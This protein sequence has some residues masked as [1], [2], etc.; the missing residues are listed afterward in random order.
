MTVH[1]ILSNSAIC[2]NESEIKL[3]NFLV[4]DVFVAALMFDAATRIVYRHWSK[5]HISDIADIAWYSNF[6]RRSFTR[7]NLIRDA[8]FTSQNRPT[9]MSP[10][11]FFYSFQPYFHSRD[12]VTSSVFASKSE[13]NLNFQVRECYMD[14]STAT[15]PVVWKTRQWIICTNYPIKT[16]RVGIVMYQHAVT[17]IDFC[18]TREM[19]RGE[20]SFHF[21]CQRSL[22]ANA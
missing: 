16:R 5:C 9:N 1:S 2:K 10:I 19:K 7:T 8:L 17:A 11:F 22:L 13:S 20:K 6:S 21:F 12:S 18:D 3:N 4:I 15:H 14:D